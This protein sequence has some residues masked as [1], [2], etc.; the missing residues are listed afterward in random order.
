MS[1]AE[2]DLE[3]RFAELRS[4]SAR[5][6]I[7]YL[8]SGFPDRRTF[9]RLLRVVVEEGADALE[10]GIP[11]S[12][13]LADGP[14]IQA[15]GQCALERGITLETTFADLEAAE[16][17]LRQTPQLLMSYLNPLRA[18]GLAATARRSA[19]A[20]ISGW[21]VPDRDLD[22]AD[23]VLRP[24]RHAGIACVPLVAPTTPAER[25]PDVLRGAGGFVYLVSLTGVTGARRGRRFQLDSY[26]RR[27]RRAT[28][29]PLCVGFGISGEEQARAAG[30]RAD[31]VIV[32]SALLEPFLRRSTARATE[33]LARTLRAVRRGL[34]RA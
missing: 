14:V 25:L 1:A 29:L 15:A 22:D 11:F 21:I 17:A 20:G 5:A 16:R 3:Q 18:A 6:M 7:P 31:G 4:R 10:V 30:R 24:A 12:D 9:R 8:M 33:E 23:E 19:K 32:G 28:D 26:V 2:N 13:P 34:D 27:V